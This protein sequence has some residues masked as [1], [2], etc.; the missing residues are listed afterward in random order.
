MQFYEISMQFNEMLKTKNASK[1]TFP[2]LFHCI[3]HKI[4]IFSV[5]LTYIMCIKNEHYF[6]K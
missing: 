5:S 1:Y 6:A 2:N 4:K 3:F